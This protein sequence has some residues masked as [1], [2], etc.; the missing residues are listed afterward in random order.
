MVLWPYMEFYVRIENILHCCMEEFPP[1]V[2][3]TKCASNQHVE[4]IRSIVT[5]GTLS[6]RVPLQKEFERTCTKLNGE[7]ICI[8]LF[9]PSFS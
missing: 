5:C 3:E 9:T 6:L 1:H 7:I 4:G 8:P 2:K